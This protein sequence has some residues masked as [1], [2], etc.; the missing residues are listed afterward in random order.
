[1]VLEDHPTIFAMSGTMCGISVSR[2][3]AGNARKEPAARQERTPEAMVARM[4][5]ASVFKA[6]RC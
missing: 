6:R 1:M 5:Q 2:C 4:I 3:F